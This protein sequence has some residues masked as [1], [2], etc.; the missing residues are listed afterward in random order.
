MSGYSL[1]AA[2]PSKLSLPGIFCYN[3]SMF[4]LGLHVFFFLLLATTGAG[5]IFYVVRS[6]TPES[7]NWW[8]FGFFFLGSFV[9]GFG[10]LTLL[11][12][13]LRRMMAPSGEPAQQWRR[14]RRQGLLLGILLV[15]ILGLQAIRLLNPLT[16][17]LLIVI[18][19]LIE[20]YVQ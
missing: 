19:L 4:R 3:Y 10:I 16:G 17:L 2:R 20:L 1:A 8:Q 9:S 6:T 7:A 13:G 12:F 5:L 11:P 15:A 14:S 18:F